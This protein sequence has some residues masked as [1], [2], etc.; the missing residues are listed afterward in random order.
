MNT[1]DI[2]KTVIV[3]GE[4]IGRIIMDM[5][6]LKV[7]VPIGPHTV[8]K[9]MPKGIYD[10]LKGKLESFLDS[11]DA[12]ESYSIETYEEVVARLAEED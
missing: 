4:D 9:D 7:T 6:N 12:V 8:H 1:A 5:N 3:E 10:Y 2:S 11:E